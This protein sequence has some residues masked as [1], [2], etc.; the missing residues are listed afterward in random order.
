[1][2]YNLFKECLSETTAFMAKNGLINPT[3]TD[4]KIAKAPKYKVDL[5]GNGDRTFLGGTIYFNDAN[6]TV[7]LVDNQEGR[8]R[9]LIVEA[10]QIQSL[11][12]LSDAFRKTIEDRK[13]RPTIA[14]IFGN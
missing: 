6:K 1:M 3:I 4:E 8:E 14:N 11:E 13:N 10:K 5:I 7:M 2:D 12:I 9:V